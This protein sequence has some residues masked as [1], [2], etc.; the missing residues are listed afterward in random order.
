[1]S[2]T[3]YTGILQVKN[4]VDAYRKGVL[5]REKLLN[6]LMWKWPQRRT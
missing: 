5:P 4:P 6:L 2:E 1:M 3:T